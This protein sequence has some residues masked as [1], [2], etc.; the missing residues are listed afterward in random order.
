MHSIFFTT[1]PY[2]ILATSDDTQSTKMNIPRVNSAYAMLEI[3]ET[4][5]LTPSWQVSL[6]SR[7]A[8]LIF[9]HRASPRYSSSPNKG[10]T[11]NN[12]I[13]PGSAT[14]NWY[15]PFTNGGQPSSITTEFLWYTTCQLQERVIFDG[16][17]TDSVHLF[18]YPYRFDEYSSVPSI[19]RIVSNLSNRGR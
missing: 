8:S 12:S 1:D 17:R 5:S 13:N 3:P 7:H 4:L 9:Y 11:A 16:T 15:D 6:R 2:R 19:D 18:P 14:Q 10:N